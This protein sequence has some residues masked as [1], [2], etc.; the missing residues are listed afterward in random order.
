MS[1]WTILL[2]AGT[3]QRFGGAKQFEILDHETNMRVIDRSFAT[4]CAVSDG[5][6]VVRPR[7]HVR[8]RLPS[9][10]VDVREIEGGESRAQSVRAGLE[11]VPDNAEI[12]CVHD[13]ARPMASRAL[14]NAGIEIIRSRRDV[15]VAG[16]IPC[17]AM[18]DT[19]KRVNSVGEVV[20]TLDRLE[21]RAVQTPQ[22]FSGHALRVAHANSDDLT[23]DAGALEA[24]DYPVL[25]FP[26][27]E[28]NR[29]ITTPGDLEWA[30]WMVRNESAPV[31]SLND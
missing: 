14:F 23:D 17:V 26:G 11:C 7:D 16:A 6:V 30:R 8:L 9:E 28:M 25:T 3:G 19:I 24:C 2:A 27:E 29:K 20:E 31:E 4:V 13:A 22:I 15:G 5:V 10:T 18:V 21:L 12:I 1:V